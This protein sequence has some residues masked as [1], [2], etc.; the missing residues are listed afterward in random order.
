MGVST[1]SSARPRKRSQTWFRGRAYSAPRL[2]EA[3]FVCAGSGVN[4]N[5]SFLI[6]TGYPQI[7]NATL[8]ISHA[9]WGALAMMVALALSIA[10]LSPSLRNF[11]AVLGGFGF[12]WFVD[13]LGKFISRDVDYLFKPALA[14]IYFVFILMFFWFR[15]LVG[16]GYDAD[17][18]VVNALASLQA[19]RL[20]ALTDR[21]RREAL[22][23]LDALGDGSPFTTD[24]RALLADTPASPPLPPNRFERGQRRLLA[25]YEAWTR[26]RS[27]VPF[28]T[29]LFAVIALA[30]LASVLQVGIDDRFRHVWS[31]V[32]TTAAATTTVMILIGGVL[33]PRNR[34]AAFRWFD[35]AVLVWI[36]VVQIFLFDRQQFGATLGLLAALAVW[37]LLRSAMTIEE[38]RVAAVDADARPS[39]SAGSASAAPAA[40]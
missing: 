25:A 32:G 26:T 23:R 12:G 7:G 6:A 40:T 21:R 11:T 36:L 17:D 9:I 39:G 29:G 8:H 1:T 10:Y 27:F 3:Y 28:V 35:R 24:V 15:H 20:G 34:L 22:D 37:A 33:L 14:I 31:F 38:Q 18:A 4:L 2:L 30:V 19:A 5:R 13:E 16:R